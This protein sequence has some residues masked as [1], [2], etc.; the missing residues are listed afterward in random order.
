MTTT[1][2]LKNIAS[3][4]EL[5]IMQ[6]DEKG[7]ESKATED[8]EDRIAVRRICEAHEQPRKNGSPVR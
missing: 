2:D 5:T 6:A 8:F 7:Q 4:M 1:K 3:H